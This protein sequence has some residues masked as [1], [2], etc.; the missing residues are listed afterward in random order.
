LVLSQWGPYAQNE[1]VGT[2]ATDIPRME[3]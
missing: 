1:R 3:V 2:H